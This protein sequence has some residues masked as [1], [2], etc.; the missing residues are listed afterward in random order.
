[1]T[2]FGKHSAN[3][4]GVVVIA[5]LIDNVRYSL[6]F[7]DG[8]YPVHSASGIGRL[9]WSRELGWR[10]HRPLF[11]VGVALLVFTYGSGTNSDK[12]LPQRATTK[13]PLL[14]SPAPA[15]VVRHMISSYPRT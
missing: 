9:Q 6:W 10:P 13:V 2:F 5:G 7:L 1:M 14:S 11:L 15:P 8:L 12:S 4:W 3:G